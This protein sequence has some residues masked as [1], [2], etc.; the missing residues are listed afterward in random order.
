[1]AYCAGLVTGYSGVY[2]GGF[3]P[4]FREQFGLLLNLQL[5]LL[6][7]VESGGYYSPVAG[8]FSVVVSSLE[9][10]M[11]LLRSMRLS[12]PSGGLTM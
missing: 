2:R 3:S 11:K 7:N 6:D 4:R 8:W 10:S 1:M 12:L 9:S 5:N